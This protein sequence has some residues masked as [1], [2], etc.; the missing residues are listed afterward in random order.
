MTVGGSSPYTGTKNTI[1][2]RQENI[3]TENQYNRHQKEQIQAGEGKGI[4]TSGNAAYSS[5]L[6]KEAASAS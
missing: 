3:G 5:T 6:K 2:I 1:Q 4:E